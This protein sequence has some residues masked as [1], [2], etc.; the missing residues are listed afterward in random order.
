LLLALI[1][2]LATA[3]VMAESRVWKLVLAGFGSG[4][5][6]A[7]FRAARPGKRSLVVGLIVAAVE[8]GIGQMGDI[9]DSRW[10]TF[11]QALLWLLAMS[12]VAIEILEKVLGSVEVTLETLQAA[13]CVYLLLGLI[14]AF[15]YTL[16]QLA[17]PASFQVSHAPPLVWSDASSRR[18]G[19]VRVFI[20]SYSTLTGTG[21][22][23]V[24]P[25]SA[26]TRMAACLEAMM[27]QIYLAVVIARLVG[28]QAGPPSWRPDAS[29]IEP[30]IDRDRTM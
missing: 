2:F 8:L 11:A 5:L 25:A 28:I 1:V 3:P 13:F 6:I 26:F 4:L 29:R 17:A 24:A 12:Y 15:F 9:H 21:Y 27:A 22:G 16:I 19:F 20:F 7:G 30:G 23:D 10:L 18:L 14:W